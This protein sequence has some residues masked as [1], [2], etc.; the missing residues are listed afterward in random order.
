MKKGN[1]ALPLYSTFCYS[2]LI[3]F[4]AGTIKSAIGFFFV[5][6]IGLMF[7]VVGV[8]EDVI[9]KQEQDVYLEAKYSGK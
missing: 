5:I 8:R 9:P 7:I 3:L 2:I 4:L 6:S 1:A